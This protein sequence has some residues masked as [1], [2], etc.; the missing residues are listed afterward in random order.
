MQRAWLTSGVVVVAIPSVLASILLLPAFLSSSL[1][2]SAVLLFFGSTCL[3]LPVAPAEAL[4]SDVVPGDLRGRAAAIRS[5]VRALTALSPLV[6]GVISDATELST[7]LAMLTP[8]YAI[9]GL[10]MLLAA[11]T[12]PADLAAVGAAAVR[13]ADA[14]SLSQPAVVVDQS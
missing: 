10:V 6:V 1:V 8:L 9:G 12:Y 11:R 14:P 7:A 13:S 2:V 3:T 4:V 5:V